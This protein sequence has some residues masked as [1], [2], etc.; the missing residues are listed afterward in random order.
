[1]ARSGN[2]HPDIGKEHI[3]VPV[4]AWLYAIVATGSTGPLVKGVFIMSGFL[5]IANRLSMALARIGAWLITLLILSM[6]YEV[7][8]RHGFNRP[9]IWAYEVAYMLSGTVF[10]FG[11]AYCLMVDSHIRVDFIY[12]RLSARNRAFIDI[13][14]YALFLLPACVW[15][16]WALGEY[17]IHAFQIQEHS[18]ESAWNPI[19]WPFRTVWALGFA[20]LVL[21]GLAGLVNAV[22]AF[23]HGENTQKS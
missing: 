21:Q 9:T 12:N 14:T 22:A 2:Q 10:I 6:V 13:L 17:A 4:V 5:S 11:I 20:A 18:G 19:V 8:A 1:M 15:L 7:I 3:R 16:T 23:R